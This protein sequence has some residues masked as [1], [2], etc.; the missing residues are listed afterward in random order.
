M[1]IDMP[2]EIEDISEPHEFR[3]GN[4]YRSKCR[5]KTHYWILLAFDDSRAHVLGI[6]RE[7]NITQA[8]TY[9]RH[10]FE[11][12]CCGYKGRSLV[13]FAHGLDKMKICIEW[14]Q[15]HD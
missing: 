4:V 5:T 14:I 7:G 3:V 12:T 15:T 13:G 1:L 9:G 10:A 2:D 11:G 6:D 8:T